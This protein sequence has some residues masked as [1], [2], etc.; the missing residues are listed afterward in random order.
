MDVSTF[1]GR[2][3]QYGMNTE[4]IRM[5][6]VLIPYSFRIDTVLEGKGWMKAWWNTA[7]PKRLDVHRQIKL[8]S[9]SNDKSM[10]LIGLP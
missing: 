9:E 6:S 8:D 1:L 10:I 2:D 7:Y 5:K 4:S 3:N